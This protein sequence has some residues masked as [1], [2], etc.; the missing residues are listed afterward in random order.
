MTSAPTAGVLSLY[1]I[2][3]IDEPELKEALSHTCDEQPFIA[4]APWVVLFAA[5]AMGLGSCYIG[6]IV[7]NAEKQRE[8]LAL[9]DYVFPAALLCFGYP[10][11]DDSRNAPPRLPL[12]V[13]VHQNRYG[14]KHWLNDEVGHDIM[15]RGLN[16][17]KM[18]FSV[19]MTRSMEVWL[20][21]WKKYTKS[22]LILWEYSIK[23]D[24]ALCDHNFTAMQR[25]AH[26]ALCFCAV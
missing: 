11:V 9:P 12:E 1:A 3:E 14:Q 10:P 20:E 16:K 17:L 18:D 6:D 8:L 15:R 22:S 7:E 13:M 19:E 26:A 5:E 21:K 23:E 25:E 4:K 2:I 24:F